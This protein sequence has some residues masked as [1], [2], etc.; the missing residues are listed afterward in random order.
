LNIFNKILIANRGEIA[1]RIIKSARNLGIKTV[2]VYSEADKD[3]LHAKSGDE[4]YF[5]GPNDLSQSYLNIDKIISIAKKADCEAIHPG[6]GFLSENPLFV[7]ACEDSGII[8]IGPRTNVMDIMGNKIKARDFVSRINVPMTRSIEGK[9]EELINAGKIMP[10]PLLIKAAAGGG[11]KGMRIVNND[12]EIKA[13]IEST[14]R[15][16]LSYFG[17]GT[18]YI[19]QFIANPRHIEVQI[20]GDNHGNLVHLF[21]RECSLQRRYQKVIE[22]SPSPTLNDDV[23]KKICETAVNIGKEIGYN[24]AGTIEFL[25]DENLKFYFLEMNTRVQVEHPV[26][27]LVTGI[28]IVREQILVAAGNTLS[29][30]QD[31]IIKNGHAI[32]CRIY[33]EDPENDFMPSPGKMSYYRE[34]HGKDIRID[35]GIEKPSVIESFFDPMISKLIVWGSDRESARIKMKDALRDYIIHGVKHNISFLITLLNQKAFIENNIST[36]FCE[37]NMEEILLSINNTKLEIQDSFIP[38]LSYLIYSLNQDLKSTNISQTSVNIWSEIGF[39]RDSMKFDIE[40]DKNDFTVSLNK[41]HKNK[42]DLEIL[43]NNYTAELLN[44]KDGKIELTLNDEEFISYISSESDSKSTVSFNGYIFIAKRKDLLM[45]EEIFSGLSSGKNE[46]FNHILS[47]I[48]GKVIKI[49]VKVGDTIKKG[50]SLIVVEAMKMENN[51]VSHKDAIISK[52][53]VK[54]NDMVDNQTQL[55][56]LIDHNIS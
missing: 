16:A 28:D 38:L 34:P 9:P 32:E 2:T 13:A 10:F 6:Y 37:D 18:V 44:I 36:K 11:G 33:A 25:V 53:N 14:S 30:T 27:E 23:R 35:G 21:E 51:L 47:H 42:Y 48:P 7:K 19:E 20:I 39:W 40:F 3:S 43:D 55:I 31:E 17:D 49:N 4:S 29:F 15:E 50:D 24:N 41:K 1:V 12:K 5:I 56:E 54:V 45:H 26:T 52:I 22:E 46:D 8:F